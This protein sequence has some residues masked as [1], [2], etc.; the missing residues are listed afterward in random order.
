MKLQLKDPRMTYRRC[1]TMIVVALNRKIQNL[2]IVSRIT[3]S[4]SRN[5]WRYGV[6]GRHPFNL[7]G[8]FGQVLEI[9]KVQGTD[10]G[11]ERSEMEMEALLALLLGH[12]FRFSFFVMFVAIAFEKYVL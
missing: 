7:T 3:M 4:Q 10:Q 2:C 11:R 9:A 6:A 8:V 12:N 5:C 1:Q